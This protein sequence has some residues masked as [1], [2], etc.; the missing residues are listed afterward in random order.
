MQGTPFGRYRLT[1]RLG[2]RYGCEV[3]RAYD[4]AID[5]VVVLKMLDQY[6][7]DET[8]ERFRREACIVAHL[9]DP[10]VV[11]IYEVAETDGRLHVA[12]RQKPAAAV[13]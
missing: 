11:P 13:L 2:Q 3:W 7:R 8:K 10:H 1:E 6:A 4:T 12:M 5:R 9:D